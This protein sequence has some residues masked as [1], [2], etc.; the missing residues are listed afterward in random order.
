MT[1]N[2]DDATPEATLGNGRDGG[3]E[4]PVL[5]QFKAAKAMTL[6]ERLIWLENKD[7]SFLAERTHR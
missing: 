3:W 7:R 2:K 5:E 1:K 4:A 6:R